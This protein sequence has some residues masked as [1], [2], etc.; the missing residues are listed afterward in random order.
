MARQR[1]ELHP[2][3]AEE[4]SRR[5]RATSVSVRDRQRAKCPNLNRRGCIVRRLIS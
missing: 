4:L 2:E 5:V 1:I 3:E